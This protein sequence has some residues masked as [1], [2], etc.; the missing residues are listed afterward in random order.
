VSTA[1]GPKSNASSANIVAGLKPRP[2]AVPPPVSIVRGP[3]IITRLT[4]SAVASATTS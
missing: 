4:S 3:S 2:R 1:D